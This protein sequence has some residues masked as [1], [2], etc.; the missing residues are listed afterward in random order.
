MTT[1]NGTG[2]VVSISA[3]PGGI[4]AMIAREIA[5][6]SSGNAPANNVREFV[7]TEPNSLYKGLITTSE[8]KE[9]GAV[10]VIGDL[11]CQVHLTIVPNSRKWS[12][13]PIAQ[14]D[15]GCVIGIGENLPESQVRTVANALV[16]MYVLRDAQWTDK[17]GNR[18]TTPYGNSPSP[19]NSRKKRKRSR[20]KKPKRERCQVLDRYEFA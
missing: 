17:K 7:T 11:K 6:P 10:V 12:P 13:K 18:Y 3:K 1:Q 4:T 19:D 14:T 8:G 16:A 20:Y 15:T 2:K 9:V 5:A